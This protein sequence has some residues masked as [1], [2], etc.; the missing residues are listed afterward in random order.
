MG[1]SV[2][3]DLVALK[4]HIRWFESYVLAS[5]VHLESDIEEAGPE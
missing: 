1:C 3:M 2:G 5:R 4:N